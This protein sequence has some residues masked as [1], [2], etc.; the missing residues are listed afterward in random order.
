MTLDELL[1]EFSDKCGTERIVAD[2]DGIYRILVDDAVVAFRE[3][4]PEVMI[5]WAEVGLLPKV[6]GDRLCRKMMEGMTLGIDTCGAA[7]SVDAESD[8]VLIHLYSELGIDVREFAM[9]LDG[10]MSERAKWAAV[11]AAASEE[12]EDT[13]PIE[14]PDAFPGEDLSLPGADYVRV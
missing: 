2:E 13:P 11:L 1:R 7:L 6:G 12:G 14:A 9:T 10:F 3:C 8:T 4:T 5:I